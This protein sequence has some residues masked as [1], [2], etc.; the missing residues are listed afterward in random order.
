MPNKTN[1]IRK[2]KVRVYMDDLGNEFISSVPFTST[3]NQ[4]YS[5]VHDEEV[6]IT[7][8]HYSINE[9]RIRA[10]QE[11]SKLLGD[12]AKSKQQKIYEQIQSLGGSDE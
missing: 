2:L 8:P 10:L 11:R 6:I 3:E 12:K 4:G 1:N 7:F 9:H 5:L